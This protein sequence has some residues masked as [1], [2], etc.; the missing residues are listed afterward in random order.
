MRT[1]WCRA[2]LT[3]ALERLVRVV[4]ALEGVEQSV[5]PGK[6]PPT[7]SGA[8]TITSNLAEGQDGN[9]QKHLAGTLQLDSLC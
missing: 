5:M 8:C 3:E 2:K 4:Q 6:V 1:L 7:P 9:F